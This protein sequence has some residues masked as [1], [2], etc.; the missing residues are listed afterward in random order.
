MNNFA[1]TKQLG[2]ELQAHRGATSPLY[3]WSPWYFLPQT[4]TSP[5]RASIGHTSYP[6]TPPRQRQKFFFLKAHIAFKRRAPVPLAVLHGLGGGA[7]THVTAAS[8]ALGPS[9][10]STGLCRVPLTRTPKTATT[11]PRGGHDLAAKQQTTKTQT[12]VH[13]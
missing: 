5:P 4:M 7:G 1:L 11:F 12:H 8:R 3:L 10:P 13:I 6:G 9:V 2:L